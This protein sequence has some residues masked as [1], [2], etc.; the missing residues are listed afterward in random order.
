MCGSGCHLN[1]SFSM[2]AP[3][4]AASAGRVVGFLRRWVALVL[5]W[6]FLNENRVQVA[7]RACMRFVASQKKTHF[8]SAIR[9][10]VS[11]AGPGDSVPL[12][13]AEVYEPGVP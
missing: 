1:V 8:S 10:E 7:P 11:A 5:V 4:S 9:G 6:L 2:N 12:V 13:R 3:Y